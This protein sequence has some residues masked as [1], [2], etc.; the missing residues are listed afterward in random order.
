MDRCGSCRQS[1]RI[2][3]ANI[4]SHLLFKGIH[5]G[6]KGCYPVR[7]K[8]TLYK[9]LLFSVHCGGGQ[10]NPF[11]FHLVTSF[12]FQAYFS[13]KSSSIPAA[14]CMRNTT[15]RPPMAGAGVGS[16]IRM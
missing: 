4:V 16:S 1:R 10:I 11:S 15:L 9:G 3:A 14:G 13:S 2:T 6:T 12:L 8:C 5:V 7:I